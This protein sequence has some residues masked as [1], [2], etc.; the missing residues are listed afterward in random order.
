MRLEAASSFRRQARMSNLS[1]N[2]LE[3]QHT[4]NAYI[5]TWVLMISTIPTG[6][7][8]AYFA[9]NNG[10][11][12][13]Y[14]P[15][16]TLL[17]TLFFD[18][19][20]LSLIGRGRKNL[21][22]M[23]VITAFSIN[24]LI[25]PF[26]VQGLGTII[27]L[28]IC[29][30]MLTVTGLAMAS[31]YV[32]TG[33]VVALLL[34]AVAIVVDF[35]LGISRVRVP[36]LEI[37]SPYIVAAITIPLITLFI[38]E[39]NRFSLQAKITLGIMLT[40]GIAVAVLVYFG[41]NRIYY[42]SNFITG[43]Y[44]IIAN[45]QTVEELT[46]VINQE[47]T[48]IDNL[49]LETQSDL[50]SMADYR[51][52]LEQK[53]DL[54]TEGV[55][56]NATDKL[57]QRSNGQYGN[58]ALEPGSVFLPSITPLSDS[59]VADINTSIYLDFIAPGFLESH[60]NVTALYYTSSFGYAIYY[61][62]IQLADNLP[63]SLNLTGRPMYTI[64]EP[65]NNPD[66]L[67]QWT[68]PYQDPLGNGMIVTVSIPVYDEDRFVGVV[69]ADMQLERATDA[70]K[71]INLSETGIPLL[72]DQDGLVI[73]MPEAGY[74]YFGLQPEVVQ[75][76]ENPT[77]SI[78]NTTTQDTQPLAQQ[79][80]F[81]DAGISEFKVNDVVVYLSVAKLNTPGYKLVFIAPESELT[82]DVI[83]TREQI[84]NQITLTFQLGSLILLVLFFGAVAASRG[85]GQFITRPIKRLTDTAERIAKGN[86]Y[87]RAKVESEDESGILARSIN[88]MADRLTETLQGLEKNVA[89][90]TSDLET[91]S[92]SSAY[93]ATLFEAIARIS[94]II[95][96][97]QNLGQLLPQ[98]T[99]TIS[100]QLGY[101]HVGIFLMDVHQ[102]FAVLVAA[103]S[104]GGRELIAR[105]HRIRKERKQ[106]VGD[107]IETG[108]PR[109]ALDF[110]TDT[111]LLSTD[112]PETRSEIALPLRSGVEIIGALDVQSK[113]QNAFTDD[114]VNILSVLADQVSIAIQNARSFQQ[115]REALDQ[116]RR[117]ASQLSEQQW[118]VFLKNQPP[119]KYHFDGVTANESQSAKTMPNNL[120]VPI[121]LR[122]V[123]IGVL[124]LSTPDPTR[125][126]DDNEIAMAQAT[127]ERTAIAIEN[128]R[129]LQD[130]QKRASKERT[131][132]Q[133][134]AKIGS[135]I[136][137]ENIVK[138]TIEELGGTLPN[139]D[140]AIQFT[141]GTAE[142]Q[143][144]SRSPRSRS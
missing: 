130:A 63:P 7:M 32:T 110:G 113:L 95:N 49:F 83:A 123:Q 61:P 41:A 144:E 112:F 120:K 29:V 91:L 27:A 92:Q 69:S 78:L 134:S 135:L 74:A 96:N 1:Q 111:A 48:R 132:G 40:G 60:P 133:I 108:K 99:E 104:E 24:V 33:L 89:D 85:V 136:N 115:S 127:A 73:S 16:L 124:N 25:V 5:I 140:V 100:S 47:A 79:I 116:A 118:S 21:A 38:R 101:Y 20:P 131:I 84:N 14:I 28:S 17:A 119:S 51:V 26:I 137:I 4:R 15:A 10:L 52:T 54:F 72:I 31:Y 19:L 125:K 88:T 2:Q 114:D 55:Y 36:E 71:E 117:A 121:V 39:F 107:V 139:T 77:L 141:S 90:R 9:Y 82:A 94:H 122:G 22:M 142:K 65:S 58:S 42:I 143:N 13:L 68:K 106:I 35:F 97:T 129:L 67:P 93:R 57:F 62:N 45:N 43:E 102:E 126:W 12:Q 138:T 64:A 105:S 50:A 75:A 18:I 109:I 8:F 23:L 53:K 34:G 46:G 86:I 70:I 3:E 76:N 44:E 37:Y 87:Y 128:A 80:V 56:W 59:L 11:P 98:I 103:N 66:R 81:S 6:G 30:V